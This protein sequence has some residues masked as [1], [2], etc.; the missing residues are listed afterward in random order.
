[1]VPAVVAAVVRAMTQSSSGRVEALWTKRAHGG[2]MDAHVEVTCIAGRGIADNTCR[3][4]TRQVTIIA[5]EPWDTMMRELGA[6]VDP[7]ARRANIMVSGVDLARS[8]GRVLRLGGVRVRI[9]GETRPCEQMDAALHG[10]RSAMETD[11]RGGAFGEMLD[12]GTLT[13]GDA[14][15]WED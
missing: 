4:T 15:A 6:A 7:A 14:V 13:V 1:M 9:R 11:W 8:R 10:L 5:R 3:S 12:D 2:V